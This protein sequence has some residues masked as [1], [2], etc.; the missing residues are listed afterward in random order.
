MKQSAWVESMDSLLLRRKIA[1]FIGATHVDWLSENR[2]QP[3]IKSDA[4][5]QKSWRNPLNNVCL[6]LLLM[7]HKRLTMMSI[8]SKIK[9]SQSDLVQAQKRWKIN[10]IK[11]WS[12]FYLRIR[13]FRVNHSSFTVLSENRWSPS[14]LMMK[15]SNIFF[16]LLKSPRKCS[17]EKKNKLIRI[18]WSKQSQFLTTQNLSN[19]AQDWIFSNHKCHKS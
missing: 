4:L 14:I 5:W 18:R 3:T 7:F 2:A 10:K 19:F 9:K 1:F 8:R 16:N 11:K 13:M 6:R 12:H 17:K 15:K